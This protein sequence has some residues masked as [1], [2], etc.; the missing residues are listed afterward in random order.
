MPKNICGAPVIGQECI[1]LVRFLVKCYYKDSALIIVLKISKYH[2]KQTNHFH[3]LVLKSLPFVNYAIVPYGFQP[4]CCVSLIPN[5]TW[6]ANLSRCTKW[7]CNRSLRLHCEIKSSMLFGLR[8]LPT[9]S[10]SIISYSSHTMM[11]VD[12]LAWSLMSADDIIR[13]QE[14]YSRIMLIMWILTLFLTIWRT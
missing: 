4:Y 5:T 2:D 13:W 9:S 3:V 7:K 1:I 11:S 14:L 10:D 8:F 12:H 6:L